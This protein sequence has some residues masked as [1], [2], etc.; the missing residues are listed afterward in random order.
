MSRQAFGWVA[1]IVLLPLAAG[2][3]SKQAPTAPSSGNSSN[4]APAPP[5]VST[6]RIAGLPG[7]VSPGSSTQLMAEIVQGPSV[8]DCPATWNADNAPVATISSSGLLT[9]ALTGY[10][11]ITA[12]CEGLSARVE[13]KVEARNPYALVLHPYDSELRNDYPESSY[14]V[15]ATV[16]FLDGPRTGEKVTTT[17]T[18]W[19]EL[20][21]VPTWPIRVRLTARDYESRDFVIAESTGHRRNPSSSVFDLPIEMRFTPDASTDTYVRRMTTEQSEI[22][23]PFTMRVPGTVEVRTWWSVDYKDRLGITLSCNNQAIGN[24]TQ[25]EG[26]AGD[27]YSWYVGTPGPCAV[28]LR[29]Y[30]SDAYTFYRVAIRYP[31]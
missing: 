20:T 7:A 3:G 16:E 25:M 30:L 27:G 14:G 9:A 2:C 21:G 22:S 1:A 28:T 15:R 10:A 13:V 19:S 31:R 26:S 6:L 29:Q 8:K 5:V 17:G 23:H 18:S 4:S 12:S 24:V 11:M